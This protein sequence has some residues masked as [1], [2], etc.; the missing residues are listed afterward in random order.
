M[1]ECTLTKV[2]QTNGKISGVETDLGPIACDY[3]VNCAGF[4][5]RSV[6]Q[7]SEPYVKVPLHAV[8]HY[9]LHTQYIKGVEKTPGKETLIF[10]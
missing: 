8:E 9:Y 3:F 6:G 4:W 1:E 2:H 5:A 7:L 10:D